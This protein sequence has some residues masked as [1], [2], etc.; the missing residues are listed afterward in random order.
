MVVA[1]IVVVVP[2]VVV[3]S[4]AVVVVVLAAVVIVVVKVKAMDRSSRSRG[5]SGSLN[6]KQAAVLLTAKQLTFIFLNTLFPEIMALA[7]YEQIKQ[8]SIKINN[9]LTNASK[10]SNWRGIA[11]TE[12]KRDVG[13]LIITCI[14][15]KS[16]VV[17]TVRT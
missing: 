4:V 9:I 11:K 16:D 12:G 6:S 7:S 10:L 8:L 5:S 3:V 1:I 17:S 14:F 15:H 2:A 13:V